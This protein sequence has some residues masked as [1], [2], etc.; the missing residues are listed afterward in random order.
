MPVPVLLEV[1]APVEPVEFAVPVAFTAV[2]VPVADCDWVEVP[3]P[4]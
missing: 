4:E 3:V 2:P 1:L